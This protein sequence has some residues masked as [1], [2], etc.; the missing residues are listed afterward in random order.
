MSSIAI[1]INTS[2]EILERGTWRTCT[3]CHESNEGH[4]TGPHSLAFDC[5]VGEGC[6]E[7]G[8]IGVIWQRFHECSCVPV[9]ATSMAG[10]C[11]SCGGL[12]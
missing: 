1:R 4:P 8:G 12:V 9:A 2:P 3:G 6:F 5:T 11:T 7:C 10:I